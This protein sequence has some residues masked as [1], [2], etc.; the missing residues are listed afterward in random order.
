MDNRISAH[1]L[2]FKDRARRHQVKFREEVLGVGFDG[3]ETILTD[4]DAQKGLIFFD[5][6][7]INEYAQWRYPQYKMKQACFANMLKS[8]RIPFNF[9]PLSKNLEYAKLY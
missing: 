2:S 1:A 3:F 7:K 9:L 8:E 5:G 4:D 6:F